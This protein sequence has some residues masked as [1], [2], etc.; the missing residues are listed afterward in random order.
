MSPQTPLAIRGAVVQ[1]AAAILACLDA[2]FVPYRAQYT[3]SAYLDTVL[4]LETMYARLA[5]MSVVVAVT[6]AGAIVGT[7]A[8]QVLPSG[9]G[10]L[11][12]MAVLPE[13]QGTGVAARLLKALVEAGAPVAE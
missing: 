12:G 13:W 1:D 11:R 9:Q 8:S 7:V 6:S 4:T 2:A 10:H 5:S 3:P